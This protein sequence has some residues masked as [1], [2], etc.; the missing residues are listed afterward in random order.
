MSGEIARVS[1]ILFLNITVPRNSLTQI[2]SSSNEAMLRRQLQRASSNWTELLA[3]L[4]YR[5][6]LSRRRLARLSQVEGQTIARSGVHSRR[7][8]RRRNAEET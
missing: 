2:F 1:Q 6:F 5:V 7:Y 3:E 8:H 4:R